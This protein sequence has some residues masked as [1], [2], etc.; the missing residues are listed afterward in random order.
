M[1]FV[2]FFCIKCKYRKCAFGNPK[3]FGLPT[4]KADIFLNKILIYI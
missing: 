2:A 4:S 1:L 3:K